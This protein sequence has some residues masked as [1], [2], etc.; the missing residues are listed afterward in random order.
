M[1]FAPVETTACQHYLEAADMPPGEETPLLQT[2]V[3]TAPRERYSHSYIRRFCT[4]ALSF[5][6]IIVLVLFLVP[7]RWL[8]GNGSESEWLPT[9]NPWR[10]TCPR[11]S[12]PRSEGLTYKELQ[13]LLLETPKE[14]KAREWSQYYTAGPHLAGRNLS[15]AVWTRELW[16][17]FG[18]ESKIIDYEIYLNYPLSHR[19]AL[20][21]E[22]KRKKEHRN[23]DSRVDVH[24]EVK[25]ECRLEEDVLEED[26][27]SGLE[28]RVPIFHGYG[29]SGNVTA[30]YVFVNFGTYKDFEDLINVG[31]ELEGNIALVKY[32]RVFRGLKIRRAQQLGMVG[33]VMYTDPEEDG[34][35][36]E[37]NGYKPY[38][39][40]PAR[41]PSSVQRGSVQYISECQC[42]Y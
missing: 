9:L 41:Q 34:E 29:A 3:I 15:Q 19:L 30:Q 12:W 27:T 26:P 20:L 39:D 17:E 42:I 40:G 23:G 25:Y 22:E 11:Q 7:G 5:T 14:E 16:Q 28:S 32:G 37:E 21:N 13:K 36:I 6:L 35:V 8:P 4:A 33:V 31:V 10:S 18:V 24:H 1:A 38:P 2:V